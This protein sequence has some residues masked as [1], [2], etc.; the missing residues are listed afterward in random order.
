[1]LDKDS[2]FRFEPDQ[3][4]DDYVYRR[5]DL[6][7]FPGKKFA[8]KRNH[9]ARFLRNAS[10]SF[11]K[12]DSANMS[13]CLGFLDDWCVS[14][15]CEEDPR[16]DYEVEALRTCL[17][18]MDALGQSSFVLRAQ[19]GIV[20]MTLGELMSDDTLVVHYE[21]AYPEHDGAYQM[22]S[23]EF[24]R[25]APTSVVWIDREQDMGVEGLRQSKL[26]FFPDHMQRCWIVRPS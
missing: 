15:G 1:M 18:H 24:A 17:G 13:E 7:E 5:E 19:G 20:G 4:N 21:K 22:L 12:V 25:T 3:S 23:R 8:R 2:R 9:V 6:A 10:W 16:L 14:H 26:S 11:D